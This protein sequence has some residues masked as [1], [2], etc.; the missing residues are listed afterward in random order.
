MRVGRVI[1]LVLIELGSE[2]WP[3][4]DGS[5]WRVQEVLVLVVAVWPA[6][7]ILLK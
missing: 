1:I 7:A 3:D 5:R 2:I 4:P 6:I